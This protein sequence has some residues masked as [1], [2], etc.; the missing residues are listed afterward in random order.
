[1][2]YIQIFFN[3]APSGRPGELSVT[4]HRLPTTATL[5]WIPIPKDKQN[6]VIT[7]YNVQVVGPDSTQGILLDKADA[8]SVEISHLDPFT[9]YTFKVSAKT[10][11]GIGPP[12][13]TS[14]KTPKRSEILSNKTYCP[15]DTCID[16]VYIM[17]VLP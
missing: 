3:S 13:S 12:A 16:Y 10:K 17:P 7:G 8:T 5:S 4:D 11:A 14:S 15:P 1:M 9:E 6:G 2:L